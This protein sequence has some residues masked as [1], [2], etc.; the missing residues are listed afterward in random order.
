MN[1]YAN[2]YSLFKWSS[3]VLPENA[4]AITSHRSIGLSENQIFPTDF[5]LYVSGRKDIDFYLDILKSKQPEYLIS[6]GSSENY[7]GFE[8]CIINKIYEEKNVGKISTRNFYLNKK[9]EFY[10]GYIY[11]I[12]YN[13][14]PQCYKK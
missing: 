12:D 8:K 11:R 14:L 4:K 1:K 6:Y 9:R 3:S 7:Y 10:N 5:L 2:G 13:K